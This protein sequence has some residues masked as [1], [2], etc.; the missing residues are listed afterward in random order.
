VRG[1]GSHPKTITNTSKNPPKIDGE[2]DAT[3]VLKRA[4]TTTLKRAP[5]R[6][7]KWSKNPSK[8]Y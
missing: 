5:K 8:T 4:M 7:P 1:R 2:I 3:F 6:V